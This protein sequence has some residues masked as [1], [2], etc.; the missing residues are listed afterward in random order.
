MYE[1]KKQE[2]SERQQWWVNIFSSIQLI[3]CSG[4]SVAPQ[5]K[6]C[7]Q[8]DFA[9]SASVCYPFFSSR[10]HLWYQCEHNH[11]NGRLFELKGGGSSPCKK[12]GK[13]WSPAMM[14]L[15]TPHCIQSQHSSTVPLV[16][17]KTTEL[18]FEKFFVLPHWT[19]IFQIYPFLMFLKKIWVYITW[20]ANNSVFLSISS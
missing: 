9:V 10:S 11:C 15:W 1:T 14:H 3:T 8:S 16:L 18:I 2:K 13:I 19:C 7:K 6:A 17:I 12:G 4:S 20:I 5:V